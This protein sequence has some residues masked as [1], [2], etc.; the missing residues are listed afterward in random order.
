MLKQRARNSSNLI[1]TCPENVMT[2]AGRE[3]TTSR[4]LSEALL[5][6]CALLSVHKAVILSS[7][8][9]HTLQML[10]GLLL[11]MLYKQAG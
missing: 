7:P 5:V 11:R 2:R 3:L 8:F 9:P 1:H 6:S 4:M 10:D